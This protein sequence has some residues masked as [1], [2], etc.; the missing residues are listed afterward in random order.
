[1]ARGPFRAHP[2]L[3]QRPIISADDDT[4]VIGRSPEAVRRVIDTASGS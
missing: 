3:I 1:V 4:T 2:I